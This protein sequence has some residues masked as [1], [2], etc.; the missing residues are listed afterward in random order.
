GLSSVFPNYEDPL[1]VESGLVI[2][3]DDGGRYDR[4][5]ERIMFPIRNV[6][7]Q[8]V[9]FGGRLIA[10]GEPKYLNS[11]ETRLFQKGRELY[12]L[13]E[14]RQ[15][16]RHESCVV[17]VEGYMDVVALAQQGIEHAVATLGTATTPEH[18]QRL[19]RVSDTII[20]SFDAD[21]AG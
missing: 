11:P 10:K 6:R 19:L 21:R 3:A 8:L 4:F 17:V 18:I 20:F 1:L 16:I 12:G 14:A 2:E 13:W 5:R 7:G 15:A 9:G